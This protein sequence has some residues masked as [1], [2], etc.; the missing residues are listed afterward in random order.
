MAR[1]A[2]LGKWHVHAEGYAQN[3]RQ[4]GS[5][6]LSVWDDD[7]PRG[8]EWAGRIGVPFETSLDKVLQNPDIDAV[9][10]TTPT[11]QHKEIIIAAAQAGKHIFTEKT[12]APT[13]AECREIEEAVHKAGVK[14][15]ISFPFRSHP[16][17][18]YAKQLM[19][20]GALGDISLY[21]HRNAHGGS[22]QN[23]LPE[24]WYDKKDACGGALMDLGCHS[25]YLAAHLFGRPK[26]VMTMMQDRIG[27][28]SD[29]NAVCVIEFMCGTIAVIETGFV[30]PCSPAT[31]ELHG[32]K[33]SMIAHHPDKVKLCTLETK[34][35]TNGMIKVD[36]L[37]PAAEMPL[38]AFLDAVDHHGPAPYGPEDAFALAE[39]LEMAY[40]SVY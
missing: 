37:P 1:I 16:V 22:S 30:T 29:D 38:K 23:W 32:T 33:G 40:N 39:I 19:K 11:I 2:M 15:T 9:I 20:S 12:L 24:Y 27:R 7:A 21:R 8:S 31:L 6:I 4:Y 10:V 5:Q 17:S 13:T 14:F 34:I 36:R 35:Y 28:G 18:L 3:V 25:I 26:K